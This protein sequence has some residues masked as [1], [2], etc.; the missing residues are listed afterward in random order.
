MAAAQMGKQHGAQLL[1]CSGSQN[2]AAVTLLELDRL[3]K[4]HID[5]ERTGTQDA[6]EMLHEADVAG[7]FVQI[8][9]DMMEKAKLAALGYR[10]VAEALAG[11]DDGA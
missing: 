3:A 9:D 6:E 5:V 10:N 4:G 1:L 11:R 7:P 8:P 2:L